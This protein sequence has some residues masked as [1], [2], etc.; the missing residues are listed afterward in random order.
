MSDALQPGSPAPDF[1]LAADGGGRVRLAD[2][3][4]RSVVLYFYPKDDTPG[5][6]REAIEFTA[7]ASDFAAAK[8]VVIGASKD[9]VRSHDKFK[10]KH[11]LAPTLASDPDGG[12][13]ER[14]GAWVQK[15]MYGKT[16]MGVDRS[17]FLIDGDGVIRRVWRKVRVPGHVAEV[18]DAV[19][20]LNAR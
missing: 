17:T 13:V 19:R 5:C 12:V 1:D 8:A 16:Y 15:S 18:L 6:T 20:G 2:F 10:A 3:S 9:S 4:G 14:Y 11:Q 7:A